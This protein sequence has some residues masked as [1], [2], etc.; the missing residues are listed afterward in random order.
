MTTTTFLLDPDNS[1][2]EQRIAGAVASYRRKF[3]QEANLVYVPLGE[4][5]ESVQVDGLRIVGRKDVLK[6]HVQVARQ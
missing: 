5:D 1:T 4:Y 6:K 3:G 2:L